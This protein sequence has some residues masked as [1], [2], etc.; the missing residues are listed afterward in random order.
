ML[1]K[2]EFFPSKEPG[3]FVKKMRVEI[4]MSRKDVSARGA[5]E[6]KS[7]TKADDAADNPKQ[8]GAD[9][10]S[11]ET[12]GG[13]GE[14][15]RAVNDK[16]FDYTEWYNVGESSEST[17]YFDQ[18]NKTDGPSNTD[19][20]SSLPQDNFEQPLE[21][22]RYQGDFGDSQ[23]SLEPGN[24]ALSSLTP[25]SSI[26]PFETS[27][28]ALVSGSFASFAANRFPPPP[29]WSAH[30]T[31]HQ[32]LSGS[33]W[34]AMTTSPKTTPMQQVETAESQGYFD[35]T[36]DSSIASYGHGGRQITD[37]AR[38]TRPLQ[39]LG[40]LSPYGNISRPYNAALHDP[41]SRDYHERQQLL[42][43]LQKPPS[44]P[45]GS[46]ARQDPETHLTVDTCSFPANQHPNSPCCPNSMLFARDST[47]TCLN[48]RVS[49][50]PEDEDYL[51]FAAARDR[52]P[53]GSVQPGAAN[54]LQ[55]PGSIPTPGT[56]PILGVLRPA[57]PCCS[58]PLLSRAKSGGI[59]VCL[60][61]HVFRT[62]DIGSHDTAPSVPST[63]ALVQCCPDPNP[64]D[65]G[66]DVS[67]EFVCLNC[68][69]RH[70][71]SQIFAGMQSWDE[72][73][74]ANTRDDADSVFA[75]DLTEDA[76]DALDL[77]SSPTPNAPAASRPKELD[78]STATASNSPNDINRAMVLRMMGYE[79]PMTSVYRNLELSLYAPAQGEDLFHQCYDADGD[80][81][82]DADN[83]DADNDGADKDDAD[84]DDADN[85]DADF[86]AEKGCRRSF[87]R[88]LD[89]PKELR[90]RIYKI[91]LQSD[92]PIAPHLCDAHRPAQQG[93]ADHG[94]AIRFHDDNQAEHNAICKTLT[95]TRVSR[96]VRAESL[97]V[98]YG[99]NTFDTVAD[100]PTYFSRLEQLG[101]FHMIRKVNFVVQ[102]WK[103]ETY[104]QKLLRMLLQHFEEQKA[105]E[106]KHGE[107]ARIN[108][109]GKGKG[110]STV[111]DAAATAFPP[112]ERGATKFF[113][114]DLEV[115]ESHPQHVM[116]GLEANFLVL[117]KLSET[118]QDGGYNR[119]L[120]IHVP[121]STLF[122]QYNSLL[123][124]P[125]VCEGLG[126]HLQLVSGRDVEMVGSGFRLSWTQKFQKKSFAES[127]TAKDDREL[128]TLTKRV[129]ALYP[130]I[131][132]VSRPAKRTYYRRNCKIRDIEWFS[133]DSAGGFVAAPNQ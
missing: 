5:I 35:P 121:T 130:N 109:A 9:A 32:Q 71:T 53:Q 85:D 14:K 129:R 133:V 102:F 92:K 38:T 93:K 6:D 54:A 18:P 36:A 57:G 115:L 107:E 114:D 29:K 96:K 40:G 59:V 128:E 66:E 64:F 55:H 120:V 49:R 41:L 47:I 126:I 100:T 31:Q 21:L 124:F 87:D 68:N 28:R 118:F 34:A 58:S 37:T 113:T 110:K 65:I 63:E 90:E 51:V 1:G 12:T 70:D 45:S 17:N 132:E 74:A 119:K 89:L 33:P 52:Q 48:C 27:G 106:M 46:R 94:K 108:S 78:F 73:M 84:K 83:G 95:I 111:K 76:D 19:G 25:P 26:S 105:F 30:L 77:Y 15:T 127:T 103:G 80:G 4:V 11:S 75:L 82:D 86:P 72:W 13:L 117:R 104:S 67:P 23:P 60:N 69:E 50:I 24:G 88:F 44:A 131:E 81:D 56:S 7:T 43:S 101:R 122:T 98:F 42:Q 20:N 2:R 91:V 116:G 10:P 125:S 123:Y 16:S 39:Y 62:E 79:E 22:R 97:P 8:F 112:H 61:C 99:T 3:R